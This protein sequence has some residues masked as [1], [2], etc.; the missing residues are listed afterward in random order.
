MRRPLSQLFQVPADLDYVNGFQELARI[1]LQ[2]RQQGASVERLLRRANLE[3]AIGNHR[4]SLDAVLEA[5]RLAPDHPE[6]HYELGVTY[7][8][9]AMS[10]AGALPVGPLHQ[11]AESEGI[12]ALL[13]KALEAFTAVIEQNPADTEAARD[14]GAIADLLAAQSDDLAL[15]EALR[16]P[17][18]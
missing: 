4:A 17:P 12:R 8:F 3:R 11:N 6:V 15:A 2:I 1:N 13:S 9:L 5:Q 16:S 14:L 10:E 18:T 7:F